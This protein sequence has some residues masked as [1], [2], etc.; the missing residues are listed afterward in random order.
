MMAN[1]IPL[2]EGTSTSG[3]TLIRPASYGTTLVDAVFRLSPTLSLSN[4]ERVDTNKEL[5]SVYAG[6][7][8]AAF[9]NEAAAKPVTG[10]EYREMTVNI[11][12]IATTV[13]YTSELLQD[14]REDPT[15]LVNA[16]VV[17]AFND[18][19]D[20]HLLGYAN[21]SQITTSFDA[22]L[23][24]S[25]QT[26]E[27]VQANQDALATAISGAMGLVEANGY[28][29]TAAVLPN[30]AKLAMRNARTT[31]GAPLYANATEPGGGFANRERTGLY[32][33]EFAYSSNLPTLAGAAAAGRVVGIVGDFSRVRVGV[34]EDV[35]MSFSTQATVDVSGTLHH[36]W[37][38]NKAA[39]RWEMRIGAN[40]HDVN[41][42]FALI[43]NAA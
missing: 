21:G 22:A 6:R 30:D 4:V 42:A 17:G 26:I 10:A 19:I 29:P 36:L 25:T 13:M 8:T 40:I 12:K 20:A 15:L 28:T 34:R 24:S 39:S 35:T 7:P 18:L 41:R 33:L 1:A 38:Q 31:T 16:D 11:K 37:Q 27:Y 2:L 5:I 43:L 9:V 3:G 32:G 14:A 23:R